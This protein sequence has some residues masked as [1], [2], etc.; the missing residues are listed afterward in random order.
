MLMQDIVPVY[1]FGFGYSLDPY[2]NS[3][4]HPHPQNMLPCKKAES[5]WKEA[6]SVKGG[7]NFYVC[8]IL[9]Q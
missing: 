4:S 5:F 8:Q 6:S 1:F 3:C 2:G 7:I 9:K